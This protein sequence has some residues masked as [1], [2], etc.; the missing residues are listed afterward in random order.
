MIEINEITSA[1]T[2]YPGFL[3]PS[4]G[5][6]QDQQSPSP[7]NP[8]VVSK[9][10]NDQNAGQRETFRTSNAENFNCKD[11]DT[12]VADNVKYRISLVKPIEEQ[13]SIMLSDQVQAE[14]EDENDSSESSTDS[15]LLG[16]LCDPLTGNNPIAVTTSP[17]NVTNITDEFGSD[18]VSLDSL[19]VTSALSCCDVCGEQSSDLEEHRARAGHYKCSHS[20]CSHSKCG[21]QIFSNVRE[22]L[23]HQQVAHSSSRQQSS[24]PPPPSQQYSIPHRQ[25]PPVQQVQR[26]PI[27]PPRHL[28][29][30]QMSHNVAQTVAQQQPSPQVQNNYRQ[31]GRPKKNMD[32]QKNR[33][34]TRSQH[35]I[36]RPTVV[37]HG[38]ALRQRRPDVVA[39]PPHIS[40]KKQRSKDVLIPDRNDNADCHVIAM[41]KRT[42]SGPVI[43]NV[44]SSANNSGRSESIIHLTDSI[45]LSVIEPQGGAV[46]GQPSTG[47]GKNISDA[48]AAVNILAS[49]GITVTL[50]GGTG[51]CIGAQQG[52]PQQPSAAPQSAVP[53][54][55]PVTVLSLDHA[56]SIITQQTSSSR[57][58]QNNF[59]VPHGRG[60]TRQRQQAQ[61]V[62]RPLCLPTVDLTAGDPPLA[63]FHTPLRGRGRGRGGRG[64][65]MGRHMCQVC[66]KAF[67]TQE[68][69][70]RHMA[71]HLSS[72]K[73]SYRCDLCSAEY[74]N[75][76]GLSRHKQMFHRETAL[77]PDSEQVIPVVDLNSSLAVDKLINLGVCHYISLSE[78][79]RLPGGCFGLSVIPVLGLQNS[80]V[81]NM[82]ST[83]VFSLGPV[84]P[85][86]R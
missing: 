57:K 37:K 28:S 44:Q 26:L 15:L 74:P 31:R 7:Q 19:F 63:P 4:S 80:A 83:P 85:L 72:E 24:K 53:T 1:E 70:N 18:C 38:M 25:S 43:G 68:I 73:L 45:T 64:S 41:Q 86:D 77:L 61:Q 71:L 39:S 49:R 52:S 40:L 50:A 47:G 48:K 30:H 78:L 10:P 11:M 67:S 46:S 79:K 69:L 35:D 56:I 9:E 22:L 6:G 59:A 76:Q 84:K 29:P 23:S 34:L 54:S 2:S 21:N 42:D 60:N 58:Q 75:K 32:Q 16:F 17:S 12:V 55:Q 51:C 33:S 5:F 36:R 62:E 13:D 66:D 81:Y 65:L 27:P 3:T 20:E 14:L 82:G 8:G